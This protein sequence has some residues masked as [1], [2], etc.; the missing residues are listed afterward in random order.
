MLLYYVF[1]MFMG[2]IINFYMIFGTNLLTQS[3]VPV[4][5]F[6]CF[7]ISQKRKIKQSPIDLKLHGTYFWIRRSP[8]DLE[9]TSGDQRGSHEAGGRAYPP[10]H[11]LHPHEPSVAPLMYFF[12]LYISTYTQTSKST[13]KI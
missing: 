10:G 13:T 8:E 3:P 6:P 9:C 5:V 12:L 2:F 7:R 1:W 4:S 11:G